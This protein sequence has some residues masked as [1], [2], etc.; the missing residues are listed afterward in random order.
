MKALIPQ[1]RIEKSIILIRGQKVMLDSDLADL[2]D[3]EIKALNRAVKRNAERFPDDFCFQLSTDEYNSLRCHFGTL[4]D[5]GRGKHRKYLPYV[6]TEQGVAML[7][8]VLKS[9]KA[10]LVNVQI[11]R[12]FVK[13]REMLIS[14]R[15][16]ARKLATLEKRYDNQFKIVFDAIRQLMEPPKTKKKKEIGF[17]RTASLQK[18]EED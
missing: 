9:K 5:T 17:V 1:E 2:Y 3:V 14:N 18:R 7:S 15:E 6:F 13:I 11:M 10:A 12:T 8:S 4:E 16:L